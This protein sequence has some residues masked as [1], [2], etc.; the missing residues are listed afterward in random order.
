MIH[1]LALIIEQSLG[2]AIYVYGILSQSLV[3]PNSTADITFFIDG[4]AMTTFSY[5]PPG[6]DKSYLYNFLLW[7]SDTLPNGAHTFSLQNGISHKRVSLI[8]FDYIVYTR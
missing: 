1:F 8:L 6:I 5:T 3:V 4:Q 2:S 7:H